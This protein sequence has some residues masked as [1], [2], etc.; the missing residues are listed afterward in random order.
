[1]IQKS[2]SDPIVAPTIVNLPEVCSDIGDYNSGTL[3]REKF[4]APMIRLAT[5]DWWIGDTVSLDSRL[6][7]L[8]EII[9]HKGEICFE[10]L[11]FR[12]RSG[13][14]S[15][16]VILEELKGTSYLLPIQKFGIRL[17]TNPFLLFLFPPTTM[18]LELAGVV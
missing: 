8:V 10:I 15:N 6:G 3:W 5:E 13:Y 7:R 17:D 16:E 2:L 12:P 11:P 4:P 14:Q 9:K 1:M 18:I